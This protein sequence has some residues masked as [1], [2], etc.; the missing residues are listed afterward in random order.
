LR[1][2]PVREGQR[3]LGAPHTSKLPFKTLFFWRLFFFGGRGKAR[4]VGPRIL[5]AF[6]CGESKT[7]SLK[8]S[9]RTNGGRQVRSKYTTDRPRRGKHQSRENTI[10]L[11]GPHTSTSHWPSVRR[12]GACKF[13]DGHFERRDNVVN[14]YIPE[15]RAIL[16]YTTL[17]KDVARI[18]MN[19]CCL[20]S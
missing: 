20:S 15:L 6:L 8:I 16:I 3:G 9:N 4:R 19:L 2:N 7:V 17:A 5:T 18:E 12:P 1:K 13:T 11:F 10:F 14:H